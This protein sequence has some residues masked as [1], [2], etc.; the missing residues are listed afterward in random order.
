MAVPIGKS[1]AIGRSRP[2]VPRLANGFWT[3]GIRVGVAGVVLPPA[4]HSC[5]PG[6]GLTRAVAPCAP[7]PLRLVLAGSTRSGI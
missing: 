6:R 3:D 2:D 4:R 5:E 7:G 1:R